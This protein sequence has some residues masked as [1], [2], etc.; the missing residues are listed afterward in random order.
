MTLKSLSF[1]L[2]E[3][4]GLIDLVLTFSVSAKNPHYELDPMEYRFP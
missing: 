2:F 1:P 3:I 4:D